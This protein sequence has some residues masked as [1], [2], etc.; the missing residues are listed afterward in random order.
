VRGWAIVT[1]LRDV[2]ELEF[3]S[4]VHGRSGHH[5][6]GLGRQRDRTV[7]VARS[8]RQVGGTGCGEGCT[9]TGVELR[10]R[11]V[12]PFGMEASDSHSVRRGMPSGPA[13]VRS[14]REVCVAGIACAAYDQVC[15]EC[16]TSRSLKG[17]PT[18]RKLLSTGGE[19]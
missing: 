10:G 7:R 17:Q 3:R 15:P 14:S 1:G 8:A 5:H 12:P 13:G 4:P 2:G 19:S 11:L 9:W 18:C 16:L 6:S